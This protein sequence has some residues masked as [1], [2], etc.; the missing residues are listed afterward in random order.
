MTASAA[1]P[2]QQRRRAHVAQRPHPRR[3]LGP[4]RLAGGLRP[5]QLRKLADDDVDRGARQ[6]ASDDRTGQE[7]GDPAEP[8]RRQQEEQGAGDQRD[9]RH[10][11]GG[12]R[13]P[14]PRDEHCTARDGGQ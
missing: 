10:Q 11:L 12:L 4:R 6:E 1:T 2:D 9:R 8:Q 13:L 14:D 7:P 5:G 3:Q